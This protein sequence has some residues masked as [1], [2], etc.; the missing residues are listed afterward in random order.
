[1]KNAIARTIVALFTCGLCIAP[2]VI[3]ES[4][5]QSIGVF[6]AMILSYITAS[7]VTNWLI[8]ED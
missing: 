7:K 3:L 4:K 8:K 2:Y 5:P 6:Y 1:M